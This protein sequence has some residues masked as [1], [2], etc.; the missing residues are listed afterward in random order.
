MKPLPPP[1]IVFG[2]RLCFS[3]VPSLVV[4]PFFLVKPPPPS[5]VVAVWLKPVFSYLPSLACAFVCEA[6]VSA[7]AVAFFGRS[8]FFFPR[9]PSLALFFETCF[10]PNTFSGLLAEASL[11]PSPFFGLWPFVVEPFF[12]FPLPPRWLRLFSDACFL[13]HVFGLWFIW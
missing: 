6:F 1:R 10:P 11:F 7:P 4:G 13:S 8:P 2:W 5:L 9:L 3:S 12:I